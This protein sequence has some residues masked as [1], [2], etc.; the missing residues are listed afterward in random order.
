MFDPDPFRAPCLLTLPF[1]LPRL[2]M[3]WVAPLGLLCAEID[4]AANFVKL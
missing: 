4:C 2:V 1:P 3:P